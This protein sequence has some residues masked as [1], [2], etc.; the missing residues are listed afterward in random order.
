MN[1]DRLRGFLDEPGSRIGRYE[2]VREIARGGMAVVYE[3]WDP[4]LR[5]KVAVK[6]LKEA[7]AARLRREAALAARLRHPNIVAVHEVGPDYIAMDFVEGRT[8]DLARGD[9]RARAALLEQVARAVAAAHEAGVVHRD[10]K[11]ANILVAPDG[12][13]VL[14]DF[15]LARAEGEE[16]L[17]RT[18]AVLGTPHYMSPEQVRGRAKEAGPAADVWALGVLLYEA[19]SGRK[20]F[21]GSTAL[22]IYD[23]IVRSDPAPLPGDLGAVALKA[24]EKDPARRTASAGAIAD[25]LAR[26]RDGRPVSARRPGAG[27]RL[28]RALRRNPLPTLAAC[29]VAIAAAALLLWSS[30]RHAALERV[31][32][33]ARISLKAALE[34]RRAGANARMREFL[35]ALESACAAAPGLAEVEHLRGR[36]HR[37]LLDD[38][39]ALA[40]QERALAKDPGYAPALYEKL[41]LLARRRD[42]DSLR[43]EGPGP[44]AS[45]AAL[46]GTAARLLPLLPGGLA[47]A[48]AAAARG[49]AGPDA[50]AVREALRLDPLLDEAWEAL[51]RIERAGLAPGMEERERRWRDAEA[52]TT[53]ALARDRGFLP[54]RFARSDLR[55]S[56]G[57]WRKDHG[58]DP[59]PDYAAAEAD[60]AEALAID[61]GSAEAFARR[62]LV[63]T[64]TA[65]YRIKFGGDPLA[66]AR[67]AEEDLSRAIELDP[68]RL[69][70]WTWRGNVRYHRGAWLARTGGDPA[71]DYEA[72]ERDFAEALRLDP[73]SSDVL[74]RRARLR[75]KRGDLEGAERDF[76]AA[77]PHSSPWAWSWRGTAWIGRDAAKADAC[78]A[79]ALG[80]D[81]EH[82]DA[83]EERGR[84]R[85][86]RGDWAGAAADWTR[87]TALNPALERLLGERL[88]EARRK[89]PER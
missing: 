18:G 16:D 65:V 40:F 81:P 15:G 56:R 59:L 60:L 6:V 89:A 3:A 17:T 26:W 43:P 1:L 58:L 63:R 35:P 13:P 29:A 71:A 37:A 27:E 72:A 68:R 31:R 80:I 75:A 54:H 39:R 46:R 51:A 53:R 52:V 20:P 50:A 66:D 82:T 11:P 33:Q 86:E 47:P 45:D 61:P 49:I 73:R 42:R 70:A 7:D 25:D 10:L 77:E 76:E 5:R 12:R 2:V 44:S 55:Q 78:F 4:E 24:L 14:T 74:M 67:G 87:A 41:V 83:W 30:E 48:E 36:M 88:G 62:G 85:F 9:V 69:L 57:S 79:R 84:A 28:V 38:D 8:L 23:R 34:L 21:D 19:V 64:Q 32:E 22:E